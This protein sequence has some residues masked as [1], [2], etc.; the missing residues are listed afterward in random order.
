MNETLK[1]CKGRAPKTQKLHLRALLTIGNEI[2][3]KLSHQKGPNSVL[4]FLNRKGVNKAHKQKFTQTTSRSPRSPVFPAGYPDENIYVLWAP[5]TGHKHLTP[6][7][8]AGIPLLSQAVTGRNCLCL[9][10]LSFPE[11]ILQ[12]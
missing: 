6:G 10:A 12:S 8:P 4:L 1:F 5:H 3:T 2:V 9:C 7:H 11:I